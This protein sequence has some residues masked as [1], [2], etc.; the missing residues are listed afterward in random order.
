MSPCVHLAQAISI[1]TEEGSKL[2]GSMAVGSMALDSMVVGSMAVDS[3]AVDSILALDSI[4]VCMAVGSK[5]R[6]RSS[7]LLT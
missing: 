5:D 7:S 2:V 6:G 1:G 4:L 3:K